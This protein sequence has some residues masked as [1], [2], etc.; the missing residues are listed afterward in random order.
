MTGA[1]ILGGGLQNLIRPVDKGLIE[2]ERVSDFLR[3]QL[4]PNACCEQSRLNDVN[5][6]IIYYVTST[7]IALQSS[8]SRIVTR[9]PGNKLHLLYSSSPEL[10]LS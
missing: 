6:D 9:S 1:R 4:S 5:Y 7:L 8:L 10:S 2:T 3:E